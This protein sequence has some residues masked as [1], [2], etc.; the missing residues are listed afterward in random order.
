MVRGR[1][2]RGDVEGRGRERDGRR[3]EGMVEK[4]ERD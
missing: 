4:R 2:D 1:R 3:G